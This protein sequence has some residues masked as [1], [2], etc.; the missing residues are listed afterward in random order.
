MK[1]LEGGYGFALNGVPVIALP[2]ALLWLPDSKTLVASDLHFEKGSAYAARGAMLP[3]F[4]TS[5]TLARLNHV[6][7]ALKPELLIALGD[8]FHDID[9]DNRLAAKDKADLLALSQCTP[10]IWIEGNHDPQVP[11]WLVGRRCATF[12]HDGL[13]F[14]HEPTGKIAGEVAGHLHP[15]ARVTGNSG[16][17]LRRRCFISDGRTLIM[18]AFGAFTGGLSVTDAAF[19][20]LFTRAPVTLI[21]S[22]TPRAP[23]SVHA[24]A[25]SKV[26]VGV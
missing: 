15:C 8:S 2:Q 14:T 17:S 4:D 1:G 5:E 20:G 6:I 12:Q 10:T 9:A 26:D 11:C 24:V 16:R 21:A 18:P 7:Q 3:P 22:G 23:G 19:D 13:H 25:L